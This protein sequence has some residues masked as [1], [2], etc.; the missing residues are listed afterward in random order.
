MPKNYTVQGSEDSETNMSQT[1]VNTTVQD[2]RNDSEGYTTRDASAQSAQPAKAR[3]IIPAFLCLLY[4]AQCAWF[5][6]TQSLTN[7]E[8]LHIFAGLDAWRNGRFQRWN[9]HPPLVYLLLTIPL[10][11]GGTEIYLPSEPSKNDITGIPR[12]EGMTPGP[13]TIAW[14]ARPLNVVLGVILGLLLWTAARRYYS[15]GAANFVLALFA[16][17]P[18]LIAHFSVAINDGAVALLTFAA[19][20]QLVAWRRQPS[21]RRTIILGLILGALLVAKFSTPMLFALTLALVLVLKP[22]RVALNPLQWNWRPALAIFAIGFMVVWATYFF[23]WTKVTLKD[24]TITTTAANRTK[25]V[26]ETFP[27]HVN[28]VFYVPGG[29]Y[30]EGLLKQVMHMRNG[31]P[32]FLLGQISQT[33]W[34]MYFPV[35]LVLKWPTIVFALFLAAVVIALFRRAAVPRDWRVLAILPGVFFLLSIFSNVDI[36]ERHILLV[37]PFV[38]LFIAGIWQF[39][40]ANRLARLLLVALVFVN[41]ADC[42]RYAPGYLSYFPI[43]VDPG[44]SYKLLSDSN[45][46]WGQGLIALRKYEDQHPGEAIHLAYFGEVDPALYGIRYE[47]LFPGQKASGTIVV[48]AMHLSGQLLD[49]P[50]A[51]AWTSNLPKKGVLD[52]C[53]HVFEAPPQ[54]APPDGAR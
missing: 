17:S 32:S 19:A 12:A 33:G 18:S 50:K 7:D 28:A 43:F 22:D 8:P 26:I 35:V 37:Y 11:P 13:E 1:L 46:D 10:L 52:H 6:G 21:W 27:V 20:L 3:L 4:V 30:V 48:S 42:L 47:P 15:E 41:A 45:L 29:E 34:K 25:P 14:R 24:G 31:H 44:T 53:L 23:H 16:F 39:A 5:V 2:V 54:I 51:Y 9:D 49:D 36:G 38:L 40:Q